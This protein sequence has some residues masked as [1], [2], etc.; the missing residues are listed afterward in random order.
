MPEP[1]KKQ[2]KLLGLLQNRKSINSR[3]TSKKKAAVIGA[4]KITDKEL[5]L[6]RGLDR[7][8]DR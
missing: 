3:L 4:K 7:G 8:L 1:M 6:L 5:S 2:S